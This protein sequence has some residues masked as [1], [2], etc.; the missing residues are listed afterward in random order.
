MRKQN[1]TAKKVMAATLAAPMMFSAVL[2]PGVE[3]KANAQVVAQATGVPDP[4]KNVTIDWDTFSHES[5]S[6]I[7]DANP[8]AQ[9]YIVERNGQEVYRGTKNRFDDKGLISGATYQYAVFAYNEY[10]R[11]VPVIDQVETDYVYQ[12][13]TLNWLKV[14]G[15]VEF[16]IE[17]NGEII[18]GVDGDTY[19]Y[20]D[21]TALVGNVYRYRIIPV[22]GSGENIEEGE[23]EYPDLQ[24][25][26]EEPIEIEPP[27]RPPTGSISTIELNIDQSTTINLDD[28]FSDPNGDILSYSVGAT[29]NSILVETSGERN[30]TVNI[31]GVK[32][33]SSSFV[34]T[35]SDGKGGTTQRTARVKVLDDSS[36]DP[37]EEGGEKPNQ[38]PTVSP[39]STQKLLIGEQKTLDLKRY[40]KDPENDKLSYRVQVNNQNVHAAEVNDV[41]TLEGLTVGESKVTVFA[42]DGTHDEV[43]AEFI[44]NV[45][46]KDEGNP[47]EP[48]PPVDPVDPVD[49]ENP[50][51]EN[52]P[53]VG[54]I[55]SN[56][57]V[58]KGKSKSVSIGR[59]LYDPE[60]DPVTYSVQTH[61]EDI[62]ETDLVLGTGNRDT[63]LNIVGKNVGETKVTV[64][65]TDDLGRSATSTFTVQVSEVDETVP[66]EEVE[67]NAPVAKDIPDGEINEGTKKSILL[68]NYFKDPDGDKLK[69]TVRGSNNNVKRILKGS[70]LTLEG[71]RAG[72]TEVTVVADDGH[73]H[74]VSRKFKIN[75]L[76]N[77][78]PIPNT[79]YEIQDVIYGPD[80]IEVQWYPVV[81]AYGYWVYL[82]EEL[83]FDQ[84]ENGS[85]L[86]HYRAEGLDTNIK[87]N[88]Q[89]VP[90]DEEGEE[91]GEIKPNPD[92]ELLEKFT[93][94]AAV[95]KNNVTVS[96]DVADLEAT[97]Y[98]VVIKNEQGEV[99]ETKEYKYA[100]AR[101]HETRIEKAGTYTA[102]VSPKI[103]GNY[104]GAKAVNFVIEKDS[105]KNKSPEYVEGQLDNIH[106][107]IG[108]A[109][110]IKN[111]DEA[112]TDPDGDQLQYNIQLNNKNASAKIEGSELTV[113]GNTVGTTT[114]TIT[115]TDKDGEKVGRTTMIYV[116]TPPNKEPIISTEISDQELKITDPPLVLDGQK[117]FED[118]DGDS[119]IV[120]VASLSNK[121]IEVTSDGSK[122]TIVPKK[123]GTTSVQLVGT[124]SKG[125]KV[126]TTFKVTVKDVAPNNPSNFTAT[127]KA[128][129]EIL[130]SYDKV[131]NAKKYIIKRNGDQITET[132]LTSYVDKNLTA[133]TSYEYEVIAVNDIG[134]SDAVKATATTLEMPKI[135]NLSA[136][137]N[138]QD[139]TLKWDE[140]EGSNNRYKVY[141]YV[142]KDDGTVMLDHYGQTANTNSFTDRNLQSETKYLYKV[143]PFVASKN[144]FVEEFGAT[145][146]VETGELNLAPIVT[147]QIPTQILKEDDT[148]RTLNLSD[149]F[150]DP[151]NDELIYE[152]KNVSNENVSVKNEGSIL[153]ITPNRAG[154]TEVTVKAIDPNGLTVE[155]QFTV[156]VLA[157]IP[158][159]VLNLRLDAQSYSTVKVSFDASERADSYII[160]RNGEV[161]KQTNE[162][163]FID[164]GLTS[165]TTYTYEVIAMNKS[166]Q[167]ESIS[168]TVTTLDMPAVENVQAEAL[169]KD[170]AKVSWNEYEGASRYRV[171]AFVRGDDG[172]FKEV[173]YGRTV[174]TTSMEYP[175]LEA[176]KEYYFN[177]IPYVNKQFE[178]AAVG[179]SN[180]IKMLENVV[181][182]VQF[183]IAL[184]GT[185]AKL[186]IKP[187]NVNGTAVTQYRI[188]RYVKNDNGQYVQE[189]NA[190]VVTELETE[191]ANLKPGKDYKFTVQPRVNNSYNNT[192]YHNSKEISV[193]NDVTPS[194]PEEGEDFNPEDI[195]IEDVTVTMNGTKAT[196]EWKGFGDVRTFKVWRYEVLENGEFKR[197]NFG[198]K[199]MNTTTFEDPDK[200]K[201]NT[202]YLYVVVPVKNNK[203]DSNLAKGG[204]GTTDDSESSGE[205][206]SQSVS[207]VQAVQSGTDAVI[208]WDAYPN[209]TRYRVTMYHQN[210]DG[211]WKKQLSKTSN[212]TTVNHKIKV[213]VNHKFEVEPLVNGTYKAEFAGTIEVQF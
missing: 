24:P 40:F 121:N 34:V 79:D 21:K 12:S 176:G 160:K 174:S 130:L 168:D 67:N 205:G 142:V 85:L 96:W 106:V 48:E 112:F 150:S 195:R 191:F 179:K 38:P 77:S 66:P 111:L 49:P 19:T 202:K 156:E 78:N 177:V 140:F 5:I 192:E 97:A 149:Y 46:E 133:S 165:K 26:I 83:V 213:G 115:A 173:G 153:S 60:G 22:D 27:N 65:V 158:A 207:N 199:V 7:W 37:P 175:S 117:H 89:I 134:E 182:P 58:E 170:K 102:S 100:G 10:G 120:S 180:T 136:S 8:Q 76:P 68:N 103:N 32:A 54:G 88:L 69:Y 114:V 15:A 47:E 61:T 98:N 129:D 181:E 198:R 171:V 107:K 6:L 93:V 17:R 148:T 163:T 184:D 105:V 125:A 82:N 4:V 25:G 108:E 210:A 92:D 196:V 51:P 135:Q 146:D 99:V 152:I 161:I 14:E 31:T 162:T 122:I 119:V 20:T 53:P 138:Q 52:R 127:A 81:G 3:G 139:V 169:T 131:E 110:F 50:N 84:K 183:D 186:S 2:V 118:P 41:L 95:N 36:V 30:N 18:A 167:S 172:Q 154:T 185:T 151:N 194:E 137:V 206:N 187:F 90:Y 74:Q 23:V 28:Y 203:Y 80:Y 11:S 86:Y 29:N 190:V 141:R 94:N 43:S 113:I 128:Y 116:E 62:I 147:K 35:A 145:V 200:L 59:S 159:P 44:V 143:V 73:G 72:E 164:T 201:P 63:K 57:K 178:D 75:V 109:P 211:S 87:N 197:S 70:T 101:Q 56:V 157:P 123:V 13:I 1:Q 55:I 124:D 16:L 126:S 33:G 155:Q 39:I 189:G 9:G 104:L 132:Q 71:T 188:Y 144:T 45:V 193:P 166:G 212:T 64:T 91:L 204:Y 209:A 208:T 42:T